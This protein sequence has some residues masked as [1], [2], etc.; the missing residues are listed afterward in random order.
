MSTFFHI[1]LIR[2]CKRTLTLEISLSDFVIEP[3]RGLKRSVQELN[4]T[5]VVSGV[6]RGTGSL[7]R[8]TVGGIVDS[9]SL[10]TETFSKNMAVLTLDR[11]YAHQRD[12]FKASG[13][14]T[15][16][17]GGIESGMNKLLHGVREGVIG[18]VRAPM[19]GAHKKGVEG[20]AKGVGK[21][22]LG[23][24]V[25]PVIGLSDA[26]TDLMVGVKG[27]LDGAQA[28]GGGSAPI[29]PRR[30]FYAHDRIMKPYN[31]MDSI[32][33]GYMMRTRLAGEK[34]LSHCDLGGRVALCS[35]KNFLLLGA[36]GEE[37]L[38]IK[39]IQMK[40]VELREVPLPNQRKGWGVFIFL[41]QARKNGS[42]VEVITSEDEDAAILL[43]TKIK[44]G[45]DLNVIL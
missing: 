6:A 40:Y 25:K 1:L 28:N 16:F 37:Q 3:V 45:I 31:F 17:V 23:L 42:E 32:A 30:A 13:V 29:R 2:P 44:Q 26:A 18:V 35:V 10:L 5:H 20:F 8:H 21:G 9:A 43:C 15:T 11:N 4:P 14:N 38:L 19:R 22:L 33:S 24:V 34:Y 36:D 27:T 41:K 12:Q 7:A 39:F